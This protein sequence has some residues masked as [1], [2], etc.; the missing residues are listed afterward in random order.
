MLLANGQNQNFS[1]WVESEL[2]AVQTL[3]LVQ[4]SSPLRKGKRCRTLSDSGDRNERKRC[5]GE[6]QQCESLWLETL[7]Q[8]VLFAVMD[9]LSLIEIHSLRC[10]NQAWNSYLT[11]SSVWDTMKLGDVLYFTTQSSLFNRMNALNLQIFEREYICSIKALKITIPLMSVDE[12]SSSSFLHNLTSC[13]ALR[14]LYLGGLG[15]CNR[16]NE[17]IKHSSLGWKGSA[18]Y[19]ALSRL[20]IHELCIPLAC[21][22]G[23]YAVICRLPC[24]STLH[25]MHYGTCNV[26]DVFDQFGY[27]PALRMISIIGCKL[28]FEDI[29][30][31]LK[32]CPNLIKIS[33]R[34]TVLSVPHNWREVSAASWAKNRQIGWEDLL[35]IDDNDSSCDLFSFDEKLNQLSAS[36]WNTKYYHQELATYHTS[37][38]ARFINKCHS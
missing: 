26:H 37:Q 28:T 35:I 14:S 18:I 25:L 8:D 27:L 32:A 22:D 19:E 36:P 9:F 11:L 29:S 20:D 2:V 12:M 4:H 1:G 23:L 24:L 10:L 16:N 38:I 30:S 3:S 7:S 21:A 34:N 15:A 5:Y 31:I 13:C 17:G 33:C 6:S